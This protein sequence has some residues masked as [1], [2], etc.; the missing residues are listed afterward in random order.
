MNVHEKYISAIASLYKNPCF[1]V[2]DGNGE[3]S[4]K[5]QHAG[6]RQGCPLS[7]YLFVIIMTVVFRD[8]Y[9]GTNVTRGKLDGLDFTDLLYADDTALLTNNI[10]AMNRLLAKIEKCAMY[11]GINF[12]KT[13]CVSFNFH[14]D[15]KTKYADGTAVPCEQSVAYLGATLS[16][17]PGSG[18]E[19]SA[20]I[21]QC[22]VILQKLQI[23]WKNPN[24]PTRFKLQVYDAV[25]RSKLVY[26]LDSVQL[27]TGLLKHLNAFQMK[28]LR[29]ILN[30]KASYIDRTNTNATILRKASEI[31]NPTNVAGK[32]VKTFSEYLATQQNKLL[33]HIARAPEDDP[34]RQCTFNRNTNYPYSVA[35]R[36]VGRPRKD[37]AWSAYENM[38]QK[39]IPT[40]VELWKADPHCYID[41]MAPRIFDRSIKL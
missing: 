25:V 12:N 21:S 1:A 34:M 18:K 23:F 40:P 26:G 4:W 6:I 41:L 22:Y 28:G 17:S 10:N 13:K 9:D 20:K 11:Y 30:M 27:N 3:S 39:N 36:R 8:V 29:K 2:R 5:K 33:C 14:V 31:K 15:G 7:P 35:K 37:W 32:N 16:K 19:V 24:C 38:L